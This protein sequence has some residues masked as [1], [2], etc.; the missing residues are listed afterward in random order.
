VITSITSAR[1]TVTSVVSH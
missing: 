1:C